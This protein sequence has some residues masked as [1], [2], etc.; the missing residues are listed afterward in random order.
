MHESIFKASL[1]ALFVSCFV[2]IGIAIGLIP[3]F[4]ILGSLSGT[5]T[6]PDEYYTKEVVEN[7]KGERTILSK[8]SPA[9]LKINID[10]FIGGEELNQKTI[11]RQLVESRE[12][13]L[14]KNRVKAI[15]L[16]INSSGG[17]VT[18]SDS[19]YR[20]L[21]TYKEQY[22]VPVYA[23]VDGMCASGAMYIACSADKIF[24]S[25]SS[26][27]GSVG[28]LIPGF[29]NFSNLLEKVGVQSLTLSAGKGK[30]EL[31]P[32]RPWKAGEEKP[33]QELINYFYA[34]FVDIVVQNRPQLTKDKLINEYGA[35][36]FNPK[37]A[38]EY[39][40]I[41]ATN[42]SYRDTLKELLKHIGITDD[43]YQVYELKHSKWYSSLFGSQALF[44]GKV[45]H[46]F[47][48]PP[49]MDAKFCN[50]FLYLYRP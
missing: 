2:M 27:I 10:G 24:A 7:A 1:R 19:I 20:S 47:G 16:Y 17:T 33:I 34:Q 43:Y 23:Y 41:T 21:K 32:L 42:Y 31:N 4:L 12:G 15:L 11:E 29:F 36:I 6:E 39:G 8:D 9:I 46:D 40:F 22:K 5:S 38:E 49:E 45:K 37:Q 13:D 14:K 25:D 18:D 50:Q 3:L 28:V 30:D 44:S 48:L 35:H 26:V